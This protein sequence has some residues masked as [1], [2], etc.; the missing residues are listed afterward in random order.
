M[1]RKFICGNWKMNGTLEETSALLA[2][3]VGLWEESYQ[4]I[5]IAVCPPFT[6][7]ASA[8]SLLSGRGV[9]IALGAQ[10]CHWQMKGAYTGEVSARMLSEAG[11]TYVILGHSERRTIFNESDEIINM[12][13]K[14]AL[15]AGLKPILC[16]G[17]THEERE[18]AQTYEVLLHQ[19]TEGL[20]GIT[21]SQMKMVAI[22]YEPVWAIG[23]G[24]TATPEI[25][26]DSHSY[27]RSEVTKLYDDG[28]ARSTL[29]LYGGSMNAANAEELLAGEDVD[30]GLIGGASLDAKAFTGIISAA[31]KFL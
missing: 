24:R 11:C 15:D 2:G 29:I 26:E 16:I 17:E 21:P 18:L 23:T 7:L 30:G 12:K 20:R 8:Q 31:T 6:S 3:I 10:N 5:E 1:R 19:L 25:A 27:I 13:V 9:R 4:D 22:A 14:S 28:I